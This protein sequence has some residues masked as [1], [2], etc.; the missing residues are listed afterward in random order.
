MDFTGEQF[1]PG[2]SKKRLADEHVE[3]YKY[4]LNFARNRTVLDIACGTGYGAYELAKE[5]QM[6]IG[7]DLS[8]ES[9]D[10]AK[11]NYDAENLEYLNASATD[12]LFA[13][14]TF[15]LI[16]SFET[17]EHLDQPDRSNYLNNLAKWLKPNGILL[18]STPNKIITS[19]FT[20][21]PLNKYHVLEYSKTDLIKELSELFNIQQIMGQRLI[22]RFFANRLVHL[23]FRLAQKL[24]S[25]DY[26]IYTERGASKVTEYN[27][28]YYEPRIHLFVAIPKK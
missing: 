22:N 7:V 5:A 11:T 14:N 2:I 4:A 9:I 3:R 20:K 26:K 28:R 27:Q 6:V 15:D 25:R 8:R 24:L 19:P 10:Y 13:E 18:L 1:I 16:C 21:K 12:E 17:I 23:L